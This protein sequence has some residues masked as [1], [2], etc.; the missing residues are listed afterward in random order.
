MSYLAA[1]PEILASAATDLA[2]IGATLSTANTAAVAATT[3]VVPSAA[4][5]V[6]A[7][8]AALFGA[9]GQAYQ[10]ASA[11]VAAFHDQFVQALNSSATAYAVAESANASP[12]QAALS[13]AAAPTSPFKQLEQMQIGFTT[14]LVNNE[15]SLNHALVANEVALEK[16]IFGTD[17]ALNGVINRSFNVGNLLLGTVEQTGNALVGVTVPANFTSGLLLGSS[18]QVFNSG[19]IGGLV[20]AFDQSLM[21]PTD[22]AGIFVGNP[23][24]LPA[25]LGV[26]PAS[27][28]ALSTSPV[29]D[30]MAQLETA[31]LGSNTSLVANE[32]SFNHALLTNEVAWE[33]GVFGTDSALNGVIN[34]SFNVANLLVGTGEQAFD[35]VV[36]AQVP[37]NFISGLLTGSGAQ[38]FNGGQIGGLVGAFDQSMMV[39]ADVVGL[40]TGT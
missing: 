2:G 11:K 38:T 8:I 3:G 7:A 14:S 28:Q 20:G 35:A 5:E 17:S 10:E 4:D 18:A 25:A 1:A 19:Q 34:R 32:T 24:P 23:T 6:S 29:A 30:F 33:K 40:L 31:Q 37:A 9:H 21:V 26:F 15:M 39:G 27:A 22:L 36:G 13:A 16:M 12:L